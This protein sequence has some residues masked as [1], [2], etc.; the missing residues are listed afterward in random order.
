M[1]CLSAVCVGVGV[2]LIVC[3]VI[4]HV[5]CLCL[6]SVRMRVRVCV[7]VW[8]RRLCVR[9]H[10]EVGAV[11]EGRLCH[12]RR[13]VSLCR[14]KGAAEALEDSLSR[15]ERREATPPGRKSCVA[16]LGLLQLCVS[17]SP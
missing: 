14:G 4:V 9:R 16:L 17:V 7:C 13:S 2:C 1:S 15:E 11:N 6:W 10:R 3:G 8:P 5:S 12:P